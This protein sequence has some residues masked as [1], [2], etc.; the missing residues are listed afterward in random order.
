MVLKGKRT[1]HCLSADI[2]SIFVVIT[3]LQSLPQSIEAN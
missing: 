3:E 1:V 2:S